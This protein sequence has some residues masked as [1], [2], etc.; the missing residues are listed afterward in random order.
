[1]YQLNKQPIREIP[2]VIKQVFDQVVTHCSRSSTKE[3]LHSIKKV[4]QFLAT[5]LERVTVE[6]GE[7]IASDFQKEHAEQNPNLSFLFAQ[8]NNAVLERT[9]HEGRC[10]LQAAYS[11]LELCKQG[12]FNASLVNSLTNNPATEHWYLV[13]PDDYTFASLFHISHVFVK[14]QPNGFNKSTLLF[15]PW[16]NQICQWRDFNPENR[17]TKAVKTSSQVLFKSFIHLFHDDA[18]VLEN[19]ISC[20][21]VYENYLNCLLKNQEI[22]L[23]NFTQF[24]Y[25]TSL[26]EKTQEELMLLAN[27]EKC[28]E[29]LLLTIENYKKEF[30]AILNSMKKNTVI[31]EDKKIASEEQNIEKIETKLLNSTLSFFKKSTDTQWKKFPE[32]RLTD[33]YKGH[34]VRFFTMTGN[35]SSQADT[36]LCHLKDIGFDVEMKKSHEKPS[37][38]VD[39]TTS[40]LTC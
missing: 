18:T 27:P 26:D 6:Y 15:D 30:T 17:Y 28:V 9:F 12:I 20:L 31:T 8:V 24:Q 1:M 11:L 36:F 16:S 33:R 25:P 40:K 19:I 34:Q 3:N 35:E 29:K 39:L 23:K 21:V 22:K 4:E 5:E 13:I 2:V 32:Q 37:L 7:T 10:H 38:V 14:V